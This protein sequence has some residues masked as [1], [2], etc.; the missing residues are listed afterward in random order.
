MTQCKKICGLKLAE[1]AQLQRSL[2]CVSAKME[3]SEH[4]NAIASTI[5]PV[6][7]AL[8]TRNGICILSSA[9]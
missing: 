9:S 8:D 5:L 7:L 4:Y 6:G 3:E 1:G 2:M